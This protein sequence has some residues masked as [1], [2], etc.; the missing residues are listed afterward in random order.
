MKL[1]ITPNKYIDDELVLNKWDSLTKV[2]REQLNDAFERGYIAKTNMQSYVLN[3]EP[4]AVIKNEKQRRL[5]HKMNT[6]SRERALLN[7]VGMALLGVNVAG[8]LTGE[9]TS[10][11]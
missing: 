3:D 7:I 5:W 9:L 6:E 1:Q 10:H 4:P 2:Q 8:A 11:N